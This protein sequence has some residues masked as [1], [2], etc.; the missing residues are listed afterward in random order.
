VQKYEAERVQLRVAT[1]NTRIKPLAVI[2]CDMECWADDDYRVFVYFGNMKH[3]ELITYNYDNAMSY[4]D[5]MFTLLGQVVRWNQWNGSLLME[6]T[7][8]KE[9]NDGTR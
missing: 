3:N 7:I 1:L 2:N 6:S 8:N 5:G 9:A 4:L